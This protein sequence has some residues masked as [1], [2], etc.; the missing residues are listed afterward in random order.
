MLNTDNESFQLK[1]A[2]LT[3]AAE[4]LHRH[5]TPSH[6][7]EGVMKRVSRSLGVDADYL[8]TPTSL[9]VAFQG[10][11]QG[12]RLMRVDA[13]PIELGKLADFDEALE[14]LERGEIAL[15]QSLTDLNA[16]DA[17]SPRYNS[18]QVALASA[19]VSVCVTVFL[20]GGWM[21]MVVAFFLGLFVHGLSVWLPR[22]APGERL[23]EFTAG[24]CCAIFA[25]LFSR[26][27][28]PIDDR[29]VTLASLIILLSLIHI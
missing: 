22:I 14:R 9:L 25:L 29:V 7:L 12:A 3:R 6:R 24:F 16:I 21:E 1:T 28:L 2:V 27:V 10:D 15:A 20:K 18:Y 26:F 23:L 5:G 13:G 8:Y 11:N 19:M 17:A 4:L